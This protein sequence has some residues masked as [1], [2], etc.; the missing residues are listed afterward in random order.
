M[1]GVELGADV[2]GDGD[3]T[4]RQVAEAAVAHV[5]GCLREG[6]VGQVRR[7]WQGAIDPSLL[8]C[9]EGSELGLGLLVRK[10]CTTCNTDAQSLCICV[11]I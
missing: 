2:C 11:E 5:E 10:M 9:V 6:P 7:D 4:C 8:L 3:D 1:C